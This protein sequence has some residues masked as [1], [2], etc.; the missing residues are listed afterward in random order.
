VVEL[1]TR[2]YV[3]RAQSHSKYE[4]ILGT[5][6]L[7]IIVTFDRDTAEAY[8]RDF[9]RATVFEEGE[10]A[11]AETV[12][13][14]RVVTAEELEAESTDALIQAEIATRPQFWQELEKWAAPLV[15]PGHD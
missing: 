1:P 14:A 9:E 4:D 7:T 12:T 11:S 13:V 8:A 2:Y 10:D 15:A 3:Q 6:W 5:G